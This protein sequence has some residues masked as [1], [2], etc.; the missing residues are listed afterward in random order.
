M[1][2]PTSISIARIDDFTIFSTSKQIAQELS[3]KC[4]SVL[5]IYTLK[6]RTQPNQGD[7]QEIRDEP[8]NPFAEDSKVFELFEKDTFNL[9]AAYFN[10]A[11][12]TRIAV[13]RTM[14]N[15]H[16]NKLKDGLDTVTIEYKQ[17]RSHL[18]QYHELIK[19]CRNKFRSLDR[20]FLPQLL[21]DD[22]SRY[23]NVRDNSLERLETKIAEIA[24]YFTDVRLEQEKQLAASA[25]ALEDKNTARLEELEAQFKARHDKLD[26][27]EK[28]LEERKK[29]LDDR[30]SK[31]ARRETYKDIKKII[32][33]RTT[34]FELTTKTN[35]KRKSVQHATLLGLLVVA[36]LF[37][38]CFYL[39]IGRTELNWVAIGSQIVLSAALATLLTFYIRWQNQW[40]KEHANEELRLQKLDLDIDRATWLVELAMEWQ[41][42]TE[43]EMPTDMLNKLSQSLFTDSERSTDMHPLESLI[44]GLI[45][46]KGEL[47]VKPSELQVK[48]GGE[49]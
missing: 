1:F 8:K 41:N 6:C 34:K 38:Y 32:K 26:E 46:K 36:G 27:R 4:E 16:Q 30:A 14:D 40:F 39:N 11:N 17:D 20:S 2:I 45:D 21:S 12:E 10:F 19:A 23:Y 31:H 29:T 18:P 25:K 3:L 9:K 42:E 5:V 43:K 7:F 35:D 33:D 22:L 48:R 28:E 24:T 44:S 13:I 37:G 47:I 49:K 15:D